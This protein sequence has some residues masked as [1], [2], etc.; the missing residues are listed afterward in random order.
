MDGPDSG[1]AED[2]DI[3][4]F[5][6]GKADKLC[7]LTPDRYAVEELIAWR[8]EGRMYMTLGSGA[9]RYVAYT[10][11]A[12]LEKAGSP[13]RFGVSL[14]NPRPI[15]NKTWT[16]TYNGKPIGVDEVIEVYAPHTKEG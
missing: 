15:G 7:M 4:L 9:D 5:L 11:N 2:G 1:V 10:L 12:L 6:A 3:K 14:T 16:F 13:C 8:T